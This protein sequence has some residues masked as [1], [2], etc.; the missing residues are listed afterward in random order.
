VTTGGQADRWTVIRTGVKK[1]RDS[2]RSPIL[3]IFI[4]RLSA[5]PSVHPSMEAQGI[6]PWSE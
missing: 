4:V 6:E 3:E 2:I 5:C 1:Q